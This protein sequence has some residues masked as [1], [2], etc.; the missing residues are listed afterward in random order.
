MCRSSIRMLS[1]ENINEFQQKINQ[2]DFA[3][4]YSVMKRN[5]MMPLTLEDSRQLLNNMDNVINMSAIDSKT[6]N[7]D[8]KQT[9]EVVNYLYK[10]FERQNTLK[11]FGCVDGIYPEKSTDI[12]PTKLTQL[13]GLSIDAL[14]PKQRKTYWWLIGGGLCL[15][16]I[17]IGRNAGI[18]P[19]FTLI[20]ATILLFGIDAI[21]YQGRVTSYL[22]THS[23]T[24]S[25]LT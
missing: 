8:A 24:H 5:P 12:S 23:L 3:G 1:D 22:L 19:V 16:E 15:A 10:R 14:T 11:G 18:D 7:I 21:A 25:Y 4:A 17:F 6:G 9:L 20:P 2:N 13:T